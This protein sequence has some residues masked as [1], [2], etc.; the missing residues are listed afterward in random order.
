M[1]P[2]FTIKTGIVPGR[3]HILSARNCQDAVRWRKVTIGSD[4]YFVAFICDGCSSG[5]FTEV[6]ASLA[7]E[8]LVTQTQSHLIGGLS[9]PVLSAVLYSDLRDYLDWLVN[10]FFMNPQDL[11]V[12]IQDYLLFTVMGVIVGADCALVLN[13]G[14]GV[15]IV[16]D[17]LKIV[18]CNN[19]PPYPAYHLVDQ[20]Y[21]SP[22]RRNLPGN[23]DISIFK[24]AE[25]NRILI[26]SDSWITYTHLLNEVWGLKHPNAVQRKMNVWSSTNHFLQDDASL[27][28][29]EKN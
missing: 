24:T 29:F 10:G 22:D 12:Y 4:E 23:F 13:A 11:S 5:K 27:A 8:F 18:D 26:G 1:S 25:I 21:L 3:D 17:D 2:S 28:I 19:E 7:A 9:V 20:K 15:I 16:N 6:G 14:D